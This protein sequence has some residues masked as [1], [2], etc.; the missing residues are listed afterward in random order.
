M[1]S[2]T[3]ISQGVIKKRKKFTRDQWYLLLLASPFMI[4]FLIFCY[5]PLF[6]WI[7]AFM[8]YKPGI[9]L[10]KTPFVGLQN[11][12]YIFMF[13]DDVLNALKNT[14]IMSGLGILTSVLPV[15]FAIMLTEVP[16]RRYTKMVQTVTTIPNFI[17]WVIVFSF[18]FSIFSREGAFNTI[19]MGLGIVSTPTN[20]LANNEAVWLFQTALG[21]W[22]GLGWSSIIYFAAITGIDPELYNAATVDGASRMQ[23]IRYITIPSISETYLVLL[24]L[25]VCNILSNGLE[26]YMVFYNALVAEHIE[27]LD[28]FIYRVGIKEADYS[29]STAVGI[30]KSGVSIL[31]LFIV[32]AISKKIRGY[33]IV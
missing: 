14:L 22:K 32:N 2:N 12:K 1:K 15:A 29:F 11:F 25:G 18:A 26:Q 10:S 16:A 23:K 31:M 28:Y 3:A 30:L 19:L 4:F 21:V 27:V 17:S 7:L 24:L 9:P 13:S 6:G 33:A 5:L 20:V 8:N